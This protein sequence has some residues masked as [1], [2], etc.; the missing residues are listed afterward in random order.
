MTTKERGQIDKSGSTKDWETR[1][2]L[3]PGMNSCATE[4]LAVPALPMTQ[5]KDNGWKKLALILV[6]NDLS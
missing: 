1:T 6:A 3:K 4:G 2:P 5:M